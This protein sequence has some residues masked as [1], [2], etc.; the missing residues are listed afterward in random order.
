MNF[1]H[2]IPLRNKKGSD[3]PSILFTI[4]LIFSIGITVVMISFLALSLYE[5]LQTTINDN[6]GLGASEANKTLATV[7][8]FEKSQWDYF[9]LAI[10]IG[11]VMSLVTLAFT[12]PTNPWFFA[13]F[14][15]FS[16]IGLFVGVALSNTWQAFAEAPALVS[17]VDRFPIT[18]LLLGNFYPLFV[19]MMI[20]LVMI[21][22]FGK[23]F[24]SDSGGGGGR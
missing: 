16:S 9:F 6:L 21:M 20:V 12:T 5:G 23:R 3:I 24:L 22:L 7:I 15:V 10:V 13:I 19:T 14:V 4:I 18:D 11:Y 1:K 17:T 8:K 2:H